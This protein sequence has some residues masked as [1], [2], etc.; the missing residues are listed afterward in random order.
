MCKG[1]LGPVSFSTVHAEVDSPGNSSESLQYGNKICIWNKIHTCDQHP[2]SGLGVWLTET[3]LMHTGSSTVCGCSFHKEQQEEEVKAINCGKF[4]F[5]L[6]IWAPPTPSASH[7]SNGPKE[8]WIVYRKQTSLLYFARLHVEYKPYALVLWDAMSFLDS[9]GLRWH[10]KGHHCQALT[11]ASQLE[12]EW[13][14]S[15][16]RE[17]IPVVGHKVQ[18]MSTLAQIHCS[19]DG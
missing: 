5:F 19:L 9:F 15:G 1:W 13:T 16:E 6:K 11:P 10:W 18:F 3:S 17:P 7:Q 8:Y 4:I 12:L 14:S 2:G